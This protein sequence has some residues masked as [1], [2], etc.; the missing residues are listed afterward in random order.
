[1]SRVAQQRLPQA[2]T[3]PCNKCKK[4]VHTACPIEPPKFLCKDCL[5]LKKVERDGKSCARCEKKFVY[6]GI[7]RTNED[8]CLDCGILTRWEDDEREKK[9]EEIAKYKIMKAE[10]EE[11]SATSKCQ[12]C[13][14]IIEHS[15]IRRHLLNCA[16]DSLE[17]NNCIDDEDYPDTDDEVEMLT[18]VQNKCTELINKIK[19]DA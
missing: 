15:K 16:I 3:I 1:M 12:I 2:R 17:E 9:Q 8:M 11:N 10:E 6:T 4:M 14:N 18:K 5:H 13:Q 19:Q 7:C